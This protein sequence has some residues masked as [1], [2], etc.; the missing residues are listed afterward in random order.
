M[1]F[2]LYYSNPTL[3]MK[4][5]EQI[6]PNLLQNSSKVKKST[7]LNQLLDINKEDEGINT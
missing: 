7:K 4:L 5:M 6:F 2:M 3:K 1:S